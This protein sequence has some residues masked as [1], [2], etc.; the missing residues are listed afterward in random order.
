M[1][2][3]GKARAGVRR[4]GRSVPLVVALVMLLGL[5]AQVGCSEGD[6][7]KTTS[8]KS[9]RTSSNEGDAPNF[10]LRSL[11]GKT[12]E[13]KSLGGKIVVIDFW[14]TWCPPCKITLPLMNKVYKKTR[15]K[16]VEVFGISTDRMPST[17]VKQFVKK[18]NLSMPILHDKDGMVSRRYGVRGIPTMFIIDQDGNIQDK[19]VGADRSLDKKV[20]KKIKELLGE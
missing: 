11:D 6:S 2:N 17:K 5:F 1:T 9:K 10:K 13:L 7:S 15:G 18:N 8:K 16:D 14:A 4:F 20:L 12:V 3:I 19:H